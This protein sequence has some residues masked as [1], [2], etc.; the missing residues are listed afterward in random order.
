MVSENVINHAK[1][2]QGVFEMNIWLWVAELPLSLSFFSSQLFGRVLRGKKQVNG[3]TAP[4]P[5]PSPFCTYVRN[6]IPKCVFNKSKNPERG[7]LDFY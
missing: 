4:F 2:V 7:D 1:V 6:L 5:L 3:A